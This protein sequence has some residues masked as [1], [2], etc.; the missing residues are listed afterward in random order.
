MTILVSGGAGYLGSHMVKLL[1]GHGFD[2]VSLD[3]FSTGYRSAI[4]GGEVID[5]DIGERALLDRIFESSSIDAVV[6]FAAAVDPA[7]SV[8]VPARY[9][10]N[11]VAKAQ[12]LLDSM[13]AHDVRATIGR[14]F[15]CLSEHTAN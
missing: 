1:L 2:V 8:R 13:V 10:E 4:L 7:E 9:Y 14:V 15:S 6:H 12:V 5:G 3:N 11:N